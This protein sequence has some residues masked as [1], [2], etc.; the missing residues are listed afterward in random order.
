MGIRHPRL[1][2][3]K[4]GG[5]HKKKLSHIIADEY[6]LDDLDAD[7]QVGSRGCICRVG[8][9]ENSGMPTSCQSRRLNNC[10]P[11]IQ[12]QNTGVRSASQSAD[13]THKH[14]HHY[15]FAKLKMGAGVSW[16][17]RSCMFVEEWKG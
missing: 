3:L 2:A 10:R 12:D 6:E 14:A 8:R 7:W 4:K 11:T 5:R 15:A 9:T 1:A 17:A 13:E 16:F